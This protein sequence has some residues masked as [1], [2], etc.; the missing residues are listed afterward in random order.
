MSQE[1]A[2]RIAALPQGTDEWLAARMF[3]V[4]G[5]RVY[6]VSGGGGEGAQ[7]AAL[8]SMCFCTFEGNFATRHGSKHE[9]VAEEAY[10]EYLKSVYGT[11]LESLTI[12]HEG[13][14]VNPDFAWCGASLDGMVTL[15]FDDDTFMCYPVEYKCPIGPIYASIPP[16]YSAQ[17][18]FGVGVYEPQIKQRWAA[19]EAAGLRNRSSCFST[20]FV[21]WKKGCDLSVR[22]VPWVRQDFEELLDRASVVY[23]DTFVPALSQLASTTHVQHD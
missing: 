18:L 16:Q 19:L 2:D 4:T 20:D 12:D 6:A 10:K 22:D 7:L 15:V 1:E 17:M 11:E 9:D 5:S 13:M 14:R 21:V 3:R 23:H 8:Q